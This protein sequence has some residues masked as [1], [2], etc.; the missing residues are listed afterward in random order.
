MLY[1][2]I[3]AFVIAL[4][5]SANMKYHQRPLPGKKPFLTADRLGIMLACAVLFLVLAL[6]DIR[7]NGDL[8][9]Y[10]NRYM[11]LQHTSVSAFLN[12]FWD[13]KDPIYYFASLLFGKLG[14]D[15]YAWKSLI[16][17]VFVLGLYRQIQYYS[18]NPA[19]SFLAI[20]TLGLYGFTF[21]G[22]RQALALSILL[23]SYPYLKNKRF[24][25]FALL[26]V[27]AAMFHST[28]LIF[29]VA[30]PVYCLK[31]RIRNL[32]FLIV[33]GVVVILN[34]NTIASFYLQ[35]TGTDEIYADYLE[36]SGALSAA[37]I[38]I[39]GCIWLFCTVFLYRK[40]ADKFDGHLCN[41]ALLA[42]FG[43]ILSAVWFAEFFRVAMYFSAFEFL[44]IADAC[45]CKE[46]S[47]FVVRF[48]TAGVS[49]AL[50]VYYFLS[51]N[52]NFLTYVM[53]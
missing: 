53:R 3:G 27:L 35:L 37:G 31:L 33:V 25:R 11:S 14:F 41:L 34:A 1:Y 13:I 48:K 43:R 17:F 21:S 20:L 39:S 26:V 32:L 9:Q 30:Y 36:K 29:L 51:P 16:A 42:L 52:G 38:I 49:L 47:T 44:M 22:L 12:Q 8:M 23:Y 40:N 45:S 4:M 50:A 19:I 18:A 7:S 15:F 46:K 5:I 24:F 10:Y 28:A 6:Q 2:V